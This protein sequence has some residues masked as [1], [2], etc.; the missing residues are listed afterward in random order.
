VLQD[1]YG[2]SFVAYKPTSSVRYTRNS[3]KIKRKGE[4][5]GELDAPM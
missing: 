1:T 4:R 2:L 5:I 3:S